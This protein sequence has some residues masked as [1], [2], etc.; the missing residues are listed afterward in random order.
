MRMTAQGTMLVY[1]TTAVVMCYRDIVVIETKP[2]CSVFLMKHRDKAPPGPCQW[3]FAREKRYIDTRRNTAKAGTSDFG[4]IM[5]N[6]G[7]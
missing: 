4:P 1:N 6:N 2:T 3:F 7:L 5:A